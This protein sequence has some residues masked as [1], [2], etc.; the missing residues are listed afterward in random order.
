MTHWNVQLLG[1]PAA[2][3]ADGAVAHLRSKETWAVLASLLL[4]QALKSASADFTPRRLSRV[5]L[6]ERFWGDKFDPPM[7]LRQALASLRRAFEKEAFYVDRETIQVAPGFFCTDIEE[8]LGLFHAAQS[9]TD[10]EQ[11]L[12]LLMQAEEKIGGDFLEGCLTS[13]DEGAVWHTGV[14]AQ[15]E[16]KTSAIL[17]AL[18]EEQRAVGH[19][20]AAFDTALR[21]L[22]QFPHS[23][24]AKQLAWDLAMDSGQET[25]LHTL[26]QTQDYRAALPRIA[27]LERKGKSLTAR[28]SRLFEALLEERL[29]AL[30]PA[31]IAHLSHLAVFPAPFSAPLAKAV[32]AVPRAS[33]FALQEAGLLEP[34]GEAFALLRPVQNYVWKRVPAPEKKTL[35]KE[36]YKICRAWIDDYR[37]GAAPRAPV[38][39]SLDEVNPHFARV[40]AS[41]LEA[42]LTEDALSFFLDIYTLGLIEIL[43]LHLDHFRRFAADAAQ[44]VSLRIGIS[45]LLGRIA[46]RRQEFSEALRCYDLCLDLSGSC[47]AFVRNQYL[48]PKAQA[49]HYGGDSALAVQCLNEVIASGIAGN[50]RAQLGDAHRFLCEI[51]NHFKDYERALFHAETARTLRDPHTE[52]PEATAYGLF[53]QGK[54]LLRLGRSTE[55]ADCID[56]AL[57]L[58]L[59]AGDSTGVGHCLRVLAELHIEEGRYVPAQVNLEHA[60]L[61]HEQTGSEGCRIAAVEALAKLCAV[62]GRESAARL[63]LEECL[64]YY[65]ARGRAEKAD[66]IRA[67]L[68][69]LF[70]GPP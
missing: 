68:I 12:A 38:F 32:C 14:A 43:I 63:H 60:L 7:H 9:C 34:Q 46:Q 45:H 70:G 58:W 15:I 26:E 48:A 18:A 49:A 39:R 52:R 61:L 51:L 40:I 21:L 3:N 35:Q 50:L 22:A 20:N 53:W 54:T 64:A 59:E 56:A 5:T 65:E 33:L 8:A 41:L 19:L 47:E 29:K 66:E 10:P 25:A 11:K 13:L 69:A 37:A 4:E 24:K 17:T 28:D 1:P 36:F 6:A 30:S 23:P 27:D 2:R 42:P 16:A 44:D 31:L 57:A 55:G 67:L 62:R